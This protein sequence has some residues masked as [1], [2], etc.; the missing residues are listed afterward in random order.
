M[1]LEAEAAADYVQAEAPR[2]IKVAGATA[3]SFALYDGANRALLLG[4]QQD[5]HEH[6]WQI[7]AGY[8]NATSS[9]TIVQVTL[10]LDRDSNVVSFQHIYRC[11]KRPEVVHILV[12]RACNDSPLAEAIEVDIRAS[13]RRFLKT[14]TAIDWDAHGRLQD[15]RNHGLAHLTP[16]GIEKRPSYAEIRSFV[17]TVTVLGECLTPFDPN[18]V[19]LWLD[20]IDD[21]SN[22]AKLVWDAAFRTFGKL[23]D[24]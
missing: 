24:S 21:W 23:S 6:A 9:L 10:L 22:H 18:G 2:L 19:P 16:E 11:L 13:V 4:K 20:E 3:I 17:H 14:Y 5:V 12:R 7:A 8:R 15:F 1:T